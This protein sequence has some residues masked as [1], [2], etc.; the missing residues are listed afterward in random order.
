MLITVN[1]QERDVAPGR[2]LHDLVLDMN[3][4]PSVVVAELNRDIVPGDRFA[5]TALN[6]GDRLELLSFVGGG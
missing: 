5:R 1:G 6:D 3:L 4:D 2:T